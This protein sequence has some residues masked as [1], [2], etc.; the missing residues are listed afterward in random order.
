[1]WLA[2]NGVF[3]FLGKSIVGVSAFWFSTKLMPTMT[4]FSSLKKN[5]ID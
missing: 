4:L 1:M 2:S 5:R 3:H